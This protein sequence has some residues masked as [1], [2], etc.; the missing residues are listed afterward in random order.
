MK[1]GGDNTGNIHDVFRDSGTPAASP[2]TDPGVSRAPPAPS[3]RAE[4]ARPG[5]PSEHPTMDFGGFSEISE[6]HDLYSK[7]K[8]VQI[9]SGTAAFRA[10]T[11]SPESFL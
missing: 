4:A 5:C 7:N 2:W 11:S 3:E 10:E 9:D 8:S 6:H 1:T